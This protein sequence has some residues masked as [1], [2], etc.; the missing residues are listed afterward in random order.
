MQP[1][2]LRPFTNPK[3]FHSTV[4]FDGSTFDIEIETPDLSGLEPS[5]WGDWGPMYTFELEENS[6]I[7]ITYR[8]H[9]LGIENEHEIPVSTMQLDSPMLYPVRK[10][11][12]LFL[13][14]RDPLR[15]L[16]FEGYLDTA[17]E[18][19]HLEMKQSSLGKDVAK[20]L[21]WQPPQPQVEPWHL[22]PQSRVA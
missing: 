1:E 6:T 9:A 18:P 11:H 20:L 5:V 10:K 2:Q 4:E 13:Y 22:E 17:G 15:G 12:P 3:R 8:C 21:L 16:D 19:A 7:R 14:F